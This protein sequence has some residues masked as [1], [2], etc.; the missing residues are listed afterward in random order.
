MISIIDIVGTVNTLAGTPR[1]TATLW[2]E[3]VSL[4]VMAIAAGAVLLVSA[5]ALVADNLLVAVVVDQ[6][7]VTAAGYGVEPSV[8]RTVVIEHPLPAQR[9]W[10]FLPAL[11]TAVTLLVTGVLLSRVV[12]SLRHGDP[13]N[14]RNAGL[15]GAAAVM[16]FLGGAGADVARYLGAKQVI[17]EAGPSLG[18]AIP[19]LTG[20]QAVPEISLS[21]VVVSVLLAAAAHFFQQGSRLRDDV[22]GLV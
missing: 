9:A 19:E 1:R 11:V 17:A 21:W 6:Q 20:A 5:G 2:L 10:I 18:T 4:A 3:V 15:I 12:R 22:D 8:Q 14:P 7:A 16:V 13:F